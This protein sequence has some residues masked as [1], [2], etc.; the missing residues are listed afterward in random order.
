MGCSASKNESLRGET[1]RETVKSG[2]AKKNKVE[3]DSAQSMSDSVTQL[4]P[5]PPI[6]VL[7][8]SGVAPFDKDARCVIFVFGT[9][10]GLFLNSLLATWQNWIK[11]IFLN[12]SL[13]HIFNKFG[14]EYSYIFEKVFCPETLFR[15]Y[16][17]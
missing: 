5:P 11:F 7:V 16:C 14:L 6:P 2:G 13:Q 3:A 1:R 8:G 10:A 9:Y 12:S 15:V 17:M 4:Q